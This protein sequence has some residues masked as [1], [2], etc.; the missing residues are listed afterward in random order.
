MK[1]VFSLML[2]FFVIIGTFAL[3]SK[4][5]SQF[6]SAFSIK[7]KAETY[8]DL[9]YEIVDGEVKITG[10]DENICGE[11]IIPSSIEEFPVTSIVAGAFWW[12]RNLSSINIPNS[13]SL[14]S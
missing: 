14:Q 13:V 8:G 7:A 3:G 11:L 4:G 2:C 9:S 1:R 5:L 10:C 12:C 6:I